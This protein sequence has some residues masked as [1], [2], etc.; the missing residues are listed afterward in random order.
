M[1]QDH[2]PSSNTQ[3]P[4]SSAFSE[5]EVIDLLR[6]TKARMQRMSHRLSEPLAVVGI[7]C[8]FPQAD[9]PDA[10]W[11]MLSEGRAVRNS[12][13]DRW[14]PGL[15]ADFEKQPGKVTCNAGGFLEGIDQFDA[16]FFGI[17]GREAATLDPQQRLLLEVAW[18]TFEHAGM[19][20]HQWRERRVG[21]FIGICS[22]DYLHQLAQRDHN[23]INTY[24]STGNS[25]GAAA[26][27]L[28]YFMG[29]RGP[30]V[31][32]DTACSSSLTAIHLAARSLRY[33]DCEL[34][35]AMGVNVILAPELSISLSQ[36][37]MLSPTGRCHTFS[38]DADGFVRGEGCG[39]VLLK[40]LSK[41]VEDGDRILCVIR[42]TASNQD[43]RS[44]GLTAPNGVA[45]EQVIRAALADAK[46]KPS[47]V[48]YVEA[49]GTGTPLGDPIEMDALQ[50]VFADTRPPGRP[51]RVG[52]VKTNVGHLE[53]AAGIAGVIKVALALHHE[54]IPP[55]LH[56]ERASTHIDWNWP[57][58][59]NAQS[60]PWKQG[61]HPRVSG[62]SSFG[63]GGSN[64]HLV[65]AEA[66][67]TV[68]DAQ[69][70][71]QDDSTQ[72]QVFVLS[73]KSESALQTQAGRVAD[74]LELQHAS[75]PQVCYT[76]AVGR[77]QFEHK[78]AFAVDNTDQLVGQLR[79]FA[80]QG[81]EAVKPKMGN[82]WHFAGA[83]I[84]GLHDWQEVYERFPEFREALDRCLAAIG[85]ELN[86]QE[87]PKPW[88][89]SSGLP[90]R[91]RVL[92]WFALQYA[93]AQMWLAWGAVPEKIS[94][95]GTGEYAG[96][97]TA[98]LLNL[99]TAVRLVVDH[100]R[101]GTAQSAAERDE[102]V[103]AAQE[104]LHHLAFEKPSIAFE[105]RLAG[106][107]GTAS[108]WRQLLE[109]DL[110][111]P[112]ACTGGCE[113]LDGP[114]C[115]P[116]DSATADESPLHTILQSLASLYAGG[117]DIAWRQ[118][119]AQRQRR[120]SLPTYS[121]E[122]RRHWFEEETSARSKHAVY[123]HLV[124][125]HPL[126]GHRFNLA[127]S[128][129]VFETNLSEFAYLKDHQ[130]GSSVVFPAT[131]LLELA[132]AAASA[133]GSAQRLV[134]D[135]KILHPIVCEPQRAC[136][137]QVVL[138][139]VEQ[140]HACHISRFDGTAWRL[141]AEC[142]LPEQLPAGRQPLK[143]A[144]RPDDCR[145]VS[146]AEH[147]ALGRKL[148]LEYGPSFQGV[149]RLFAA[150]EEAWG[151]VQL[152]GNVDASGYAIHPALLDACLQVAGAALENLHNAW[153]PVGIRSYQLHDE[154]AFGERLQV[155]AT[156][157]QVSSETGLDV[158]LVVQG[159]DGRQIATV[160]QLSLKQ[161]FSQPVASSETARSQTS[162]VAARLAKLSADDQA[163]E[164]QNY[165]HQHVAKVMGMAMDEVPTDKS[166]DSLGLDSLMAFELRDELERELQ[167][168]IPMELFLE[169]IT[170]SEFSDIVIEKL[171]SASATP[172]TPAAGMRL[173]DSM[174]SETELNENTWIEGG[175]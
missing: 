163:A 143:L 121:F 154:P 20:P 37:G 172:T 147:Y 95:E 84:D 49:H 28:S 175:I 9:G 50:T 70:A 41:A 53:G 101:C 105:S 27:R 23:T 173:V 58:Q 75:L 107:V 39:A 64:A 11:Q 89:S 117:S 67:A 145:E 24:L 68:V 48:D 116:L 97:C 56:C 96:A 128:D 44:N 36:A 17:T 119:F 126:L 120:V 76:A 5:A 35:L 47:E 45:Q 55:H 69:C 134:S 43:G 115:I 78:V 3:R 167:V 133:G 166:L 32:I 22:N 34:A 169:D 138:S 109:T 16:A 103:Q 102:Q 162:A 153:V 99:E 62:V 42:G 98:G 1:T 122:R 63:F 150:D 77:A 33:G 57:V 79:K 90:S 171:T 74:W 72:R 54:T 8:R 123:E 156:V 158:F 139:P 152:P 2:T 13:G 131:G 92:Q 142:Q 157:D 110:S 113:T 73:A 10:F 140:G 104:R 125:Q 124:E 82:V 112:S 29:W 40:R 160:D 18:E 80:D 111:Q 148:K 14:H 159:E 151:E 94:A 38:A 83:A 65:L 51:L 144:R 108:H 52:S 4:A 136:R 135:L 118:V 149:R 85:S 12:S 30:S 26:G 61:A 93:T 31:A 25:H 155:Y 132:L 137:V 165:L 66:P 146:V 87:L 127:S 59:V 168:T 7:G 86:G 60:V 164:L 114:F 88:L 15:K 174:S 141:C 46:T 91:D 106:P 71:T 6:Q 100:A 21:A 129:I 130:I 19:D 161:L 81:S 170:L